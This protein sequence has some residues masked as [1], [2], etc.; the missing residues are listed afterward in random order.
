MDV[1]YTL[2]LQRTDPDPLRWHSGHAYTPGPADSLERAGA[3]PASKLVAIARIGETPK[4]CQFRDN[5]FSSAAFFC[6]DPFDEPTQY[7]TT[8][9]AIPASV[10]SS[11]V[12]ISR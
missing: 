6:I 11:S 1:D 3:H 9:D 4:E 7:A 2:T 10:P 12:T 5:T 8:L